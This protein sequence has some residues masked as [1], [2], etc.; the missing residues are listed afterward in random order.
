MKR[1]ETRDPIDAFFGSQAYAVIGVSANRKKFGNV[2]YRTLKEKKFT[3]FPVHPTMEVVEGDACWNSVKDLPSEV[4]S[5]VTV[6]PPAQTLNVVR[7]C[8]EKGIS[9]IWMQP[10]SASDEAIREANERGVRVIHGHCILMFLE[11]VTSIHSIH[12]WI[13]KLVGI[14]PQ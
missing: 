3:V 14:Y 1:T 13:N 11:P 8:A 7:E 9:S 6:I 2:V 10:G 5:V 4:A 12:R